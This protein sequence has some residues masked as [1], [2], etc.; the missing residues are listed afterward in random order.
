MSRPGKSFRVAR[1]RFPSCKGGRRV[2]RLPGVTCSLVCCSVAAR[3]DACFLVAL[4]QVV[5]LINSG[6]RL[7]KPPG[8]SEALYS[9]LC[10]ASRRANAA[11]P[12]VLPLT[13]R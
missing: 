3:A 5:E 12:C 6:G 8:C 11:G 1:S 10:Q 4:V 7:E 2:R 9:L 13:I